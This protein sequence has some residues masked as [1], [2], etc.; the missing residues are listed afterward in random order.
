MTNNEINLQVLEDT[1][2]PGFYV[3]AVLQMKR[4]KLGIN[5]VL[6]HWSSSAGTDATVTLKCFIVEKIQ[7]ADHL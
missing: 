3:L 4:I 7:S 6:L 1:K 5:N 2:N